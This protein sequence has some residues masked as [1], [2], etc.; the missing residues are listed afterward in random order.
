ML[1]GWEARNARV[2]LALLV[3]TAGA[4]ACAARK[5]RA[6]LDR[7][8]SQRSDLSESALHP[9]KL[10]GEPVAQGS[11]IGSP[12][13]LSVQGSSLWL[14][15]RKGDPFIHLIDVGSRSI[16]ESYGRAGEG[17]G[18]FHGVTNLAPRPGDTLA[19]WAFDGGLSRMTRLTTEGS[20]GTPAV[21]RVPTDARGM[22]ATWLGPDRLL[23]VGNRDSARV[24]IADTSGQIVSR[25]EAA[26]LGP[27]SIPVADRL[28]PS[29]GFV[30]CARPDGGRAAVAFVGG[31]RIDV[32]D[33]L[34]R[35]YVQAKVPF[36]SDGDYFRDSH[37]QWAFGYSRRYY[38]DCV[39]T[40]RYLYALFSGRRTDGPTGGVEIE[41]EFVHVFTWDGVL[42]GVFQLDHLMSTLAVSGDTALFAAG[43]ETGGVLRYHLKDSGKR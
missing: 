8:F 28:P 14:S 32:L 31:G 4:G 30:L 40:N 22:H 10:Q 13:H 7:Y 26:L 15:D 17:P 33:S 1:P 36:P 38:A 24:S 23:V 39:A 12:G 18:D 43:P 6:S 3:L 5:S 21:F 9:I 42:V 2:L 27:D 16:L 37:G 35:E 29:T 34:G 20:R 19:T 25:E 11:V 41:A